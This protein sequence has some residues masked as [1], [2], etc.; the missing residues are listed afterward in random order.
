MFQKK[1]SGVC[2]EA[3]R[4]EQTYVVFQGRDDVDWIVSCVE[5]ANWSDPK[6]ITI[7]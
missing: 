5:P 6:G 7:L 3:E 1:H 4:P 2:T